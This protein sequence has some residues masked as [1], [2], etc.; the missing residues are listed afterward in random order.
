VRPRYLLG[1]SSMVLQA[2]GGQGKGANKLFFDKELRAHTE[3]M[4]LAIIVHYDNCFDSVCF[5]DT[6]SLQYFYE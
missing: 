2:T 1:A 4:Y 6:K 3:K 5:P